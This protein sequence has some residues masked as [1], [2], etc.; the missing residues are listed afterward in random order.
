[1]VP[2]IVAVDRHAINAIAKAHKPDQQRTSSRG[3]PAGAARP[4][5]S[6]KQPTVRTDRSGARIPSAIRPW[7]PRH[8][9]PQR[10]KVTHGRTKQKR[11]ASTRIRS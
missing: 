6:V 3:H 9:G 1:M 10:Y 5:T 11:P 8:S 4:W 2:G 7:T